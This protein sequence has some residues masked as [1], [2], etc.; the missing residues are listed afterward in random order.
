MPVSELEQMLCDS[1][2]E[3]LETMFFTSVMGDAVDASS[4]TPWI[5]ARLSF[6]GRPSGRFGVRVPLQS[7][8]KIAADFLGLEADAVSDSQIGEVVG[9]LCNMVCGSVLSRLEKDCRFDLSHPEIEAPDA[10]APDYAARRLLE[11]EDG[12]LDVWLELPKAL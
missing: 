8:R 2:A 11:L 5:S 9:E 7:G 6:D 1:T 10:T 4:E 3:V 12:T